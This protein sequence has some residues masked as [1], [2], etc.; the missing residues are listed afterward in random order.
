MN[1]SIHCVYFVMFNDYLIIG[2]SVSAVILF[3]FVVRQ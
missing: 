2:Y 1:D 3:C